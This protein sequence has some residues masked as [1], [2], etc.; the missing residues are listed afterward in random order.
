M[1]QTLITPPAAMAVLLTDALET[2]RQDAGMFDA[3]I[4]M[5]IRGITQECEHQIRRAL[6]TQQWRLTLD[7][8][9]DAL[10]L[11]NPPTISVESV[12]YYDINNVLQTLDPA[13][14]MVDAVTEPG[15]VVPATGKAWPETYDRINAVTVDYTVGYGPTA[16]TVP[17]NVRSYILLR[18]AQQFDPASREF[19]ET[20]SSMFIA[21]LLDRYRVYA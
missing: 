8:F 4:T 12:R 17:D 5:W 6:I 10:R 2:L 9:D 13:D 3:T 15:Y 7:S 16:A 18:L 21:R 1:T 11:A 19:K 14:Y 20:A